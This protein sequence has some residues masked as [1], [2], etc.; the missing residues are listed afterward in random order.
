M[1]TN[2]NPDDDVITT[3]DFLTWPFS[4]IIRFYS[5]TK[6][7]IIQ[8]PFMQKV[9][10]TVFYRVQCALFCIKIRSISWVCTILGRLHK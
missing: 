3:R 9:G 7:G 4:S 2:G 10:T 5:F 8:V 1:L 6:L